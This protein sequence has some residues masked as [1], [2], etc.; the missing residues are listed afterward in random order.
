[1]ESGATNQQIALA[2][3]EATYG[4]GNCSAGSCG[5]FTYYYRTA[6]GSCNCAKAVGEL[7]FIYSNTGYTTIGQDYGG[8]PATVPTISGSATS[9]AG[10]FVRRKGWADCSQPSTWQLVQPNLRSYGGTTASFTITGLPAASAGTVTAGTSPRQMY[11]GSTT[12]TVSGE[13]RGSGV[14][15]SSNGSIAT[16]N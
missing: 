1:M 13:L 12:Y 8:W 2:A 3:C 11:S 9:G 14:Q 7:E 6:A 5:Y 15:S 16:V 10:P 4:A